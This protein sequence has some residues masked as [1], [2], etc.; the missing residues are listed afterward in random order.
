[1]G[2]RTTNNWFNISGFETTS[3]KQLLSNQ[4]RWWPFRFSQLR[5]Q[6]QNNV[7][8]ALIKQT[9][10]KEGMNVEFRAEAL[11]AF[12]HPY[13]PSPIMTITTAQSA[14]N[15]G[16]GQINASTQDNYARRIQLS[17]RFLF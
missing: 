2:E 14:A 17:I 13:F 3:S 9:L 8:L 5:R 4:L 10:I 16:F 12:N 11:N 7:D 6:R 1:L 15:T